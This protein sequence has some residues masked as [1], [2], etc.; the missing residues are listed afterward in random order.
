MVPPYKVS[1][2]PL[3][4]FHSNSLSDILLFDVIT[5][6]DKPRRIHEVPHLPAPQMDYLIRYWVLHTPSTDVKCLL[7]VASSF[8]ILP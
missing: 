7:D 1:W 6:P 8:S 3:N 4:G 2:R 5:S